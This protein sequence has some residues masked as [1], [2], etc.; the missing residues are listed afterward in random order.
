[1]GATWG[2]KREAGMAS[3]CPRRR[4][5]KKGKE[6]DVSQRTQVRTPQM[7]PSDEANQEQL[8]LAR[9]QGDAFQQAVDE[10]TRKEAHGA[11]QRAGDYLVGYA[12]E[13]AEGLY[14]LDAGQLRWQE[15]QK[16]NAHLEIVVRDGADGRFIPGLTVYAT[17]IDASGNEIGTHRQP[18]LWHPWLYHYGRNWVVPGDGEYTLRVKVEPPDFHRHD[19][20]NGLRYAQTVEAEFK[21]VRIQTGQKRS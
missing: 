2:A 10:M 4:V 18:F 16:E 20:T 21:G 7:K 5:R 19:K 14:H 9:Q 17:L 6:D 8:R 13:K 11:E 12:V 3:A 1:M 15:P